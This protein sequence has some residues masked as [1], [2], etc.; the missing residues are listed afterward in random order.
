MTWLLTIASLVGVVANIYRRR[1]CF[2]VWMVTNA[3]WAAVD[4]IHGI[5]SQAALM[6]IYFGLAVWGWV[7]WRES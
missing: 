5:W 1:W 6:A 7:R 4:A 3:S 2:L